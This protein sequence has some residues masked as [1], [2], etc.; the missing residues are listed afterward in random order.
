[1]VKVQ[2]KFLSLLW[3]GLDL[4]P[5]WGEP[6]LPCG[7]EEWEYIYRESL[8][9]AVCGIV[10]QAVRQLPQESW[11]GPELMER[12]T[13]DV[14]RISRDYERTRKVVAYQRGEWEKND[15]DATLM[16]G[17]V[18]A[19]MY[20]CP[21]LRM[22]GDIDWYVPGKENWKRALEL[23]RS[24]GI[25]WA[26][27]SDGGIHYVLDCIV[28]EHH[29][30]GLEYPGPIGELY[31][32]CEHILHHAMVTG[33]GFKHICDYF[34]ALR[35]YQGGYDEGEYRRY[36]KNRGIAR[37]DDILRQLPDRLLDRVFRDGNMGL[38]LKYRFRGFLSRAVFF[39]G[40]CPRVY[41]KRWFGLFF[42]RIGRI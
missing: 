11:P 40:V 14:V 5:R 13:A 41:L 36:L 32:R 16:K 10:W 4:P 19:A 28:V 20:P 26:P 31:L 34:M 9:Q 35:F 22:S 23:L 7:N 38:D 15:I 33:V 3:K 18:S 1:M 37:W 25:K 6:G 2:Y 39:L 30:D 8:R 24:N 12:W 21:E 42:G 29:R 17:L 27:D